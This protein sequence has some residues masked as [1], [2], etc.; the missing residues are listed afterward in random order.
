M[1]CQL[2]IV[3][4]RLVKRCF[5]AANYIPHALVDIHQH[6]LTAFSNFSFCGRMSDNDLEKSEKCRGRNKCSTAGESRVLSYL[7]FQIAIKSDLFQ[8]DLIS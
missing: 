8:N 1:I 6:N 2:S 7:F 3:S 5:T 4:V